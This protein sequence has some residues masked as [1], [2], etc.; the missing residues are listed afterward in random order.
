MIAQAFFGNGE[1]YPKFNHNWAPFAIGAV[2]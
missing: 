1:I 2:A